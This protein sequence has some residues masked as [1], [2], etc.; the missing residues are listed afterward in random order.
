MWSHR[1]GVV[2]TVPSL[3]PTTLT[4]SLIY[5]HKLPLTSASSLRPTIRTRHS[6]LPTNYIDLPPIIFDSFS[7]PKS[8]NPRLPSFSFCQL[9]HTIHSGLPTSTST[10]LFLDLY[11][12]Y[13]SPLRL[14]PN[15]RLS[16]V[17]PLIYSCR[18]AV[19]LS[20]SFRK[21]LRQSVS[22]ENQHTT[23]SQLRSAITLQPA[24]RPTFD[25]RPPIKCRLANILNRPLI[26]RLSSTRA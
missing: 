16:T 11:N 10:Y 5:T 4:F 20:L 26:H 21:C 15:L 1:N 22:A 23:I 8:D 9:L 18:F 17:S 13:T 7:I 19:K 3:P 25:R 2:L 12:S 14:S 24:S 6:T